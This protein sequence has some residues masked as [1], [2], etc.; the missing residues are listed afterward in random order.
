M[1][2]RGEIYSTKVSLKNRTYFFNVKEN[3]MGDLY[4]NIVESKNKESG[5]FERQSVILFADDLGEFLKGFDDSLR[6]L[7]K[8][9]KEKRKKAFSQQH[10]DVPADRRRTDKG[11]KQLVYRKGQKD[12]L[13]GSGERGPVKKDE[14]KKAPK[15]PK[16]I[17][18][19]SLDDKKKKS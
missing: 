2:I 13:T 7:E 5:G 15:K 9:H 17:K 3:R 11:P 19:F 1:G 18:T 16:N 4:L 14:A 6:V 12:T 8:S 10:G